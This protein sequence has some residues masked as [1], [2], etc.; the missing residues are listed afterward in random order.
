MMRFLE[1]IYR[2]K[3]NCAKGIFLCRRKVF[4]Y[5]MQTMKEEVAREIVDTVLFANVLGVTA[6]DCGVEF[7]GSLLLNIRDA[8]FHYKTMCDCC[9]NGEDDRVV[10]HYYSIFEHLNRGKKDAVISYSR[11]VI[12]AVFNL[13]QT[14]TFHKEFS[15][16]DIRAFRNNIHR[17]K[18]TYLDLRR[19]GMH[20]ADGKSIT[21]A[22][23]EIKVCTLNITEICKQKNVNL[24]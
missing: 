16:E 1:D 19:D 22:W 3:E 13:L 11:A 9:D 23:K 17:I 14:Q 12:D 15:D 21:Q 10:K 18:N 6:S 20:L 8:M 2:T 4:M 7:S 24:F 5:D